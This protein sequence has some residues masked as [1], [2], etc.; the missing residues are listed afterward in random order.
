MVACFAGPVFIMPVFAAQ[1]TVVNGVWFMWTL[2]DHAQYMINDVSWTGDGTILHNYAG[3][4]YNLMRS[5]PGTPG[6]TQIGTVV[7][8]SNL[9]FN[10]K[11]ETGNVLM[12]ATLNFTEANPAKN[13]YGVGTIEAA[14]VLKITSMNSRFPFV[15]GDGEGFIVGTH[16]TG[17][18]ENAKLTADLVA[19]PLIWPPGSGIVKY[20]AL[21]FGVHE[22]VNGEGTLVF[23]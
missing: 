9:V 11:T 4:T 18:F 15:F 22:Q 13:P 2:R 16:G 14:L 17:A 7:S 19:H 23:H 6:T 10:T 12:K 3:Y 5:P 21:F 8:Q 1:P 20:E